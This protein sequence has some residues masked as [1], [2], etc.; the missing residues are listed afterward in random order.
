MVTKRE[1]IQIFNTGLRK[2][3]KISFSIEDL[4]G[5]KIVRTSTI[6]R[7]SRN[8]QHISPGRYLQAVYFESG[9]VMVFGEEG[10]HDS[11]T[12]HS[13]LISRTKV[14]YSD[15]IFGPDRIRLV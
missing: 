15:E 11:S 10:H 1:I 9:K 6:D 4:V 7:E 12:F 14:R 2:K 8:K 3:P 13:Y 5:E